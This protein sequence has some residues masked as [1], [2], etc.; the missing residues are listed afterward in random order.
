MSKVVFTFIG[1]KG[2][3]YGSHFHPRSPDVMATCGADGTCRI[4][5]IKTQKNVVAIAAHQNEV[6][7]CDFNKY[8]D[9]IVTASG[10]KTMKLWDLR[11]VSRPLD[12]LF[13][14]RYPVKKA[15][16]SPFSRDI[17]LSCSYDM[18]VQLW[19]LAD[20]VKRNARTFDRHHEFVVGIDWSQ[21][22]EN[23]V[24]SASWD[25]KVYAWNVAGQQPFVP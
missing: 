22:V 17:L 10:D 6:L 21:H 13:G 19:N 18:T 24:A 23:L 7:A 25:G 16:W 9:I 11:N 2:V 12:I 20:P 3:V 8:D 14:H 1:H 5:D 15:K 4:W